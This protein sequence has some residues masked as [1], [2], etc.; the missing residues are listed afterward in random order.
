MQNTKSLVLLTI[1][2]KCQTKTRIINSYKLDFFDFIHILYLKKIYIFIH[3]NTPSLWHV[4]LPSL[5][6]TCVRTYPLYDMSEPTLSTTCVRT[7]PLYDMSGPT[8]SMTCVR[9]Y[10]LYDICQNLPSLWHVS[11]PTLSMTCVICT[12][13]QDN[14]NLLGLGKSC[15]SLWNF[16]TLL[17]SLFSAENKLIT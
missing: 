11:E 2:C 4:S 10:P 6:M 16:S 1:T 13:I 9:T 15:I 8:L 14:N 3:I 17:F 7:Y 12:I 5:S